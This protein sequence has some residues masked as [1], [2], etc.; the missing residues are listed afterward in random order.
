MAIDVRIERIAP[1]SCI[2]CGREKD[3]VI[4]L[5]FSDKSFSGPMCFADFR[6]ALAMKVG[7]TN[8][9][10]ERKP[11]VSVPTANSIGVK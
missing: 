5:A 2:W 11:S 3:Q 6:K 9:E 8:T 1:G 4:H 10:P 7:S